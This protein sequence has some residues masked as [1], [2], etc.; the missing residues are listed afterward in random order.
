[1]GV[2]AVSDVSPIFHKIWFLESLPKGELQTGE[3][4]YQDSVAIHLR[5]R[6]DFEAELVKISDKAKFFATLKRI[7]K[8]AKNG[9]YP[10]L[11]ID[12]HGDKTGIQLASGEIVEWPALEKYLTPINEASK[13]NLVVFLA[14][15]EGTWLIHTI[16]KIDR[17]SFW[18]IIA[19]NVPVTAGSIE[20]DCTKFYQNLLKNLNA[21]DAIASLNENHENRI[22]HFFSVEGLFLKAF[23]QYYRQFCMGQG[24]KKRIEE[25]V[26]EVLKDSQ[27]TRSVDWVRKQVKDRLKNTEES[28]FVAKRKKF[29][30]IDRFPEN[31]KRFSTDFK[32]IQKFA[33][34]RL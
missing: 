33:K 24:R 15:C 30:F 7:E 4:I 9:K 28:D 19:P 27:V 12:C 34:K 18:G 1:M 20:S 16:Q 14:A 17:A 5:N 21:D 13:V 29:F 31:E 32:A 3:H 6:K 2:D 26:T 11:H 23:S 10:M 22:Y 25:L 8:D